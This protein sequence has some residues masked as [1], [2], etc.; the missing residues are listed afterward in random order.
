MKEILHRIFLVNWP[1]K[2]VALL[3]ALI[4]WFLVNQSVTVTKTFSN[5]P[6]RITNLPPY[7]TVLG[8]SSNGILNKKIFLT[9][10][11]TKGEIEELNSSEVEVRINAEGKEESFITKI[12]KKN[13][14]FPTKEDKVKNSITDVSSPDLFIKVT[15]LITGEIPLTITP[16]TGDSPPGFQ[17]LDIAPKHLLQKVSGPQEEIEE[18]KKKGLEVT[19][20]LEKI[21]RE[22]LEAIKSTQ[23]IS[24]SDEISFF[25]PISW[26]KVTIAFQ[27]YAQEPMNDPRA[28]YLRID[29]LK[30][31]LL[32]LDVFLPVAL[33]Y[34]VKYSNSLNPKTYHLQKT[35]L[36]EEKNGLFLLNTPLYVQGVSRH[37]LDIVKDNMALS[38]IVVPKNIQPTLNWTL[39]FVDEKNLEE[40]FISSLS[41]ERGES[42]KYNEDILRNRFRHYLS[43]LKLFTQ[44]EVPLRLTFTLDHDEVLMAE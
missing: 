30:Q 20:N 5:I 15:N 14:F 32:S 9:L 1:R 23:S 11:G 16:P 3:S 17:F 25:I 12:D 6:V 41:K 26:K 8:L 43:V 31:E 7:K 4:I 27:D 44:Q 22:E 38:V 35:P 10:T 24:K 21:S 33:F 39:L 29:F 40:R 18:L 2:C 19:F 28:Q 37:F 34:P 36:L 13:L 42:S